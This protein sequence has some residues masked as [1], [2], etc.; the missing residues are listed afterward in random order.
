MAVSPAKTQITKFT[1]ENV[2]YSAL[3]ALVKLL[4]NPV[5]N[6]LK[7]ESTLFAT[8][9]KVIMKK[10]RKSA[11]VVELQVSVRPVNLNPK[12]FA[13]S[14]RLLTLPVPVQLLPQ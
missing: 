9:V 10:W 8:I 2:Y 6:V 12:H 11:L 5:P 3:L 13:V 14:F 4:S 1:T 7:L